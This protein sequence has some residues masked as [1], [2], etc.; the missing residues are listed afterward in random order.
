MPRDSAVDALF[1]ASGEE[2]E[3][4]H[5]SEQIWPDPTP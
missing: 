2:R 4:E 1:R 3:E 5:E